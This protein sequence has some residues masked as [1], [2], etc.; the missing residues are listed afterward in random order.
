MPVRVVQLKRR[1][2]MLGTDGGSVSAAVSNPHSGLTAVGV[3]NG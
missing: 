1:Q 2:C 3:M